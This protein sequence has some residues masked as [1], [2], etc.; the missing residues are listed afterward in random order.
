LRERIVHPERPETL[1][2]EGQC[3]EGC[4]HETVEC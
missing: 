2:I 1:I 3:P 4:T